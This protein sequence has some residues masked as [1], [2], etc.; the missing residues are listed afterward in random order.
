[1]QNRQTSRLL[2]VQ[3]DHSKMANIGKFRPE[4]Q[5]RVFGILHK[6][7][8]EILVDLTIDKIKIKIYN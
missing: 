6:N 7:K 1:M 3:I 4:N 5:N 2:F 8:I